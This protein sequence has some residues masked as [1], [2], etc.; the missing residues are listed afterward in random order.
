MKLVVDEPHSDDL[1][2]YLEPEA[3]LATSGLALVEVPRAVTIADP[4]AR[5]SEEAERLLDACM[6]VE[7]TDRLLR[8][9]ARLA[10][11]E[12]R[13]LDAIHL[14]SALHVEADELI[15]YDRRLLAGAQREGIPSRAPGLA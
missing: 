13:T 2:A 11:R 7:P 9:A 14:A 3:L 8:R 15:A 12:L 1:E 4:S 5:A 6:I 10:S